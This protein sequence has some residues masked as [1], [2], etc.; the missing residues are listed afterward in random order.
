MF[1]KKLVTVATTVALGCG[2]T[3]GITPAFAD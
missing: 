2:F 3:F 1:T